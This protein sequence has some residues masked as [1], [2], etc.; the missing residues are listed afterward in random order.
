ML[1][2][3]SDEKAGVPPPSI[4]LMKL[5]VQGFESNVIVGAKRLFDARA[6]GAIHS[7]LDGAMLRAQGSSA[8]RLCE[9]L[10]ESH[11]IVRSYDGRLLRPTDCAAFENS[12]NEIVAVL[13]PED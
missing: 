7:E 10:E 6:I 13:N 3:E 1:W 4:P 5:D 11:M 8:Q 9:Q 2:P 12:V